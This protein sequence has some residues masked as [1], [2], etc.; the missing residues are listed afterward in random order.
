MA[1]VTMAELKSRTGSI[2]T[3]A[4]NEDVFITR[5]GKIVAKL[6]RAVPDKKAAAKALFGILPKDT[7]LDRIRE[8]K[9]K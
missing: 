9:Y 8:E 5:N 7:D 3:M 1:R 4:Q 6:T 2:V